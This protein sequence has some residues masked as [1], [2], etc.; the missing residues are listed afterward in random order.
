M[1]ENDTTVPGQ[2]GHCCPLGYFWD[3]IHR[4]CVESTNC[5]EPFDVAE[6]PAEYNTTGYWEN[7]SII[8][9]PG[10]YLTCFYSHMNRPDFL[11]KPYDQACCP[12]YRYGFPYRGN[13]SLEYYWD[14]VRTY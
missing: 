1:G 4:A 5:Y 7:Q 9:G 3:E 13:G 12:V 8:T 2:V 14:F 11:K 10:D 6:C